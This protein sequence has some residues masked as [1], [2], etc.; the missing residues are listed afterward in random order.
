MMKTLGAITVLAVAGSASAAFDVTGIRPDLNTSGSFTQSSDSEAFSLIAGIT[1][2]TNPAYLG[3]QAAADDA[4]TYL[5]FIGGEFGGL[6]AL[7]P[8]QTSGAPTIGSV[9]PGDYFFFPPVNTISG[10]EGNI[11]GTPVASA[12]APIFGDLDAIFVGQ[13]NTDG[14][15]ITG[16][17]QFN[18]QG[19]GSFDFDLNGGSVDVGFEV[20][21]NFVSIP[22]PSGAD[23]SYHLYLVEVPTPGAAALLGVAGLAGIRRR[24]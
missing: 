23:N 15:E 8:P 10:F 1:F 17:A 11:L 20:P 4:W 22:N 3:L 2:P 24:R 19:L 5:A 7:T 6:P 9:L 18:F 16:G 14:G 21:L 13:I 12:P